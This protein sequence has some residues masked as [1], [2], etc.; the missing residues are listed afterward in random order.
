MACPTRVR[1]SSLCFGRAGD[2]PKALSW[3]TELSPRCF[4]PFLLSAVCF[5]GVAT[6]QSCTALNDSS[7]VMSYIRMKPMAPR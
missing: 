5:L 6:H 3:P 7:L 2:K 4:P 1:P